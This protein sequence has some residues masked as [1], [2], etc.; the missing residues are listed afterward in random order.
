MLQQIKDSTFTLHGIG[1]TLVHLFFTVGLLVCAI[2]FKI[3]VLGEDPAGYFH[4]QQQ[5]QEEDKEDKPA[6]KGKGK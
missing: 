1:T 2:T 5:Q 6:T 4:P 3:F